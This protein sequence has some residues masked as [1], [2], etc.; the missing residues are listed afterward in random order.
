MEQITAKALKPK[1]LA[2]ADALEEHRTHA[3]GL[4]YGH[5]FTEWGRLLLRQFAVRTAARGP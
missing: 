5:A 1:D 2:E 3:A 4:E